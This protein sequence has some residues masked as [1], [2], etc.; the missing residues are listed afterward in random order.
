[1][2]AI[3]NRG[4]TPGGVAT[5][6]PP[7]HNFRENGVDGPPTRRKQGGG[8]VKIRFHPSQDNR[9]NWEPGISLVPPPATAYNQAY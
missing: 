4:V 2:M 6:T 9:V 8:A 1:M 5:D 7:I 3:F